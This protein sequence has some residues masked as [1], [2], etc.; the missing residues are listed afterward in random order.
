MYASTELKE[1][2]PQRIRYVSFDIWY[3]TYDVIFHMWHFN[4]FLPFPNFK[5][6]SLNA[7][8]KCFQ[9]Y[10]PKKKKKKK[11]FN[12]FLKEWRLLKP[13]LQYYSDITSAP[14]RLESRENWL[15]VQQMVETDNKDD[16]KDPCHLPFAMR[17]H[18]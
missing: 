8:N 6:V 1:L 11:W 5:H 18:R 9:P 16:I 15:F 13:P 10:H 4:I 14:C 2:V 7:V 12:P 17:A 3:I